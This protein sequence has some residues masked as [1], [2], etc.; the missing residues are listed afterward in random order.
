MPVICIITLSKK[1]LHMHTTYPASVH[2]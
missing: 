2:G 1:M